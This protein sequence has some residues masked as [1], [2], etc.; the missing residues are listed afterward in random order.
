M[1]AR[2]LRGAVREDVCLTRLGKRFTLT[3]RDC[4]DDD[5]SSV[6]LFNNLL[7][8]AVFTCPRGRS[9]GLV[10]TVRRRRLERIDRVLVRSRLRGSQPVVLAVHP[11]GESFYL[12][13]SYRY[14]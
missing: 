6:A 4:A 5:T 14:G 8:V 13:Y 7:F 9:S 12:F 11:A 2:D 3:L 10:G 1:L